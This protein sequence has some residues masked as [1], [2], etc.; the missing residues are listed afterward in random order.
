MAITDMTGKEVA[1]PAL[2]NGTVDVS[3]LSSG[4]YLLKMDGASGT[5]TAKFTKE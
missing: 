5:L 4:I 3:G 1:R 2:V